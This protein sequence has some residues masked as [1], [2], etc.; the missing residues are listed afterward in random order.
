MSVIKEP[1]HGALDDNEVTTAAAVLPIDP[2]AYKATGEDANDTA[3]RIAR[4]KKEMRDLGREY[5]R[6][7]EEL[8]E[9]AGTGSLLGARSQQEHTTHKDTGVVRGKEN[10]V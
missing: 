7:Q 6:E 9:L 5:E 3:A 2:S 4:L 1:K 8:A 10:R